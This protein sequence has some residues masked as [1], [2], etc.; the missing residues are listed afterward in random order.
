M[1]VRV[2]KVE[3]INGHPWIRAIAEIEMEGVQLRGLKLE[4]HPEGWRLTPPGRKI[5]GGW[6]TVF[7]IQDRR[8]Q[9][10]VLEMVRLRHG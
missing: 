1:N 10:T 4:Q 7:S 3:K 8:L 5:N 9:Q 2:T 6:Q